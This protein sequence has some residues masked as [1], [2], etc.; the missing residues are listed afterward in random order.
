[1]CASA[2]AYRALFRLLPLMLCLALACR[3]DPP[4]DLQLEVAVMRSDDFVK[5]QDVFKKAALDLVVSKQCTLA[6]LQEQGGWTK[7]QNHKTEPIYFT[8]CG[9]PHVDDRIYLDASNG[10]ILP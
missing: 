7:S 3:P 6:Q 9:R 4:T 10:W 5:Y 8:Y 2:K 1:M